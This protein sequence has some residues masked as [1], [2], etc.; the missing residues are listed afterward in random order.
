MTDYLNEDTYKDVGRNPTN[1][2]PSNLL[3]LAYKKH[4]A[5]PIAALQALTGKGITTPIKFLRLLGRD[6]SKIEASILALT[7][8]SAH[9]S[10]EGTT[11][12]RLEVASFFSVW[13]D[14][15]SKQKAQKDALNRAIASSEAA[16]AAVP[17][18]DKERVRAQ[19]DKSVHSSY[20]KRTKTNDPHDKMWDEAF[21]RRARK[22][23]FP[24]MK[25]TES[26][27]QSE[28]VEKSSNLE[29]GAKDTSNTA[30]SVGA[31][32]HLERPHIDTADILRRINI[33][34]C[35]AYFMEEIDF[36][37]AISISHEFDKWVKIRS[38][39]D[40]AIVW[41]DWEFRTLIDDTLKEGKH[42]S[43]KQAVAAAKLRLVDHIFLDAITQCG[44]HRGVV[45]DGQGG[46]IQRPAG[47]H[48]GKPVTTAESTG[49][50]QMVYPASYAQAGNHQ[51]TGV[52][53][54]AFGA[55]ALAEQGVWAEHGQIHGQDDAPGLKKKE[56]G[57]GR[58][59]KKPTAPANQL[60]IVPYKPVKGKGGGRTKGYLG[61]PGKVGA[62]Q[63]G[64]AP[65]GGKPGKPGK[66]GQ[67]GKNVVAPGKGKE[68]KTV[69]PTPPAW[70]KQW[71]AS[72][73][74]WGDPPRCSW[75][76]HSTSKCPFAPKCQFPH[77]CFICASTD[78]GACTPGYHA[79]TEQ[80][81]A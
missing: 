8:I 55:N 30:L 5:E 49:M 46:V 43:F 42:T 18:D 7:D 76:N 26:R 69:F 21:T 44:H 37:E 40:A 70:E 9:L 31:I 3:M 61:K 29:L 72:L 51:Q 25:L 77:A 17:E 4:D 35:L 59:V 20:I 12:R 71:F 41:A 1:R 57:K 19:Y 6:E 63:V 38:P 14:L 28:D 52:S 53:E 75:H 10:D 50:M 66:G 48:D 11:E 24:K 64:A 56:R 67:K 81:F 36:T 79:G 45:V 2:V 34:Y 47:F 62:Q 13:D 16:T 23:Y 73:S 74:T 32:Y 27:S 78:H 54:A 65:V 15:H 68:G 22:G 39:T 33:L 60:A 80:P 58:R